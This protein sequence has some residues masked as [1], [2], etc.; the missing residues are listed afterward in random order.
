MDKV[1]RRGHKKYTL[2][3]KSL[4]EVMIT[5]YTSLP[6]VVFVK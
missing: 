1:K 2:R 5:W 3:R 4:G 6:D